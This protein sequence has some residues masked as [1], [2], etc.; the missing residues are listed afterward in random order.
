MQLDTVGRGMRAVFGT[1]L[2][3]Y[4]KHFMV[5]FSRKAPSW[6]SGIWGKN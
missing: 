4:I 3:T 1:L 5:L 2:F 6:W